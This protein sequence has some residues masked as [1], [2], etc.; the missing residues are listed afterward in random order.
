MNFIGL[1]YLFV[2]QL[3]L[4]RGFIAFFNIKLKP[5]AILCMSMMTGI[6]L[7][8][9][10][11]LLLEFAHIP[12]TATSVATSVAVF[13][14][15][16]NIPH[17]RKYNYKF[18][19]PEIKRP[20]I[21][22]VVF[23]IVLAGLM[24]PAVWRC[25]YHPPYARDVL[26]GAEA[27]AEYTIREKSIINSVFT[28]DLAST[29]NHLKPPYLL[30]LQII[31]KLLVH[32]FGQVW[33]SMMAISFLIWL[34]TLLK[35]KLHPVVVGLTMLFFIS[36][37]DPYAYTY[38]I[39]YDYSCMIF[40][41][42]GFYF[43]VKYAYDNQYNH[44]LFSAF[45]FG[46]STYIRSETL[47]L[48]GMT[49]P[50]MVYLFWRNKMKVSKMIFSIGFTLALSYFLYFIWMGIFVKHYM[51]VQFDVST[52]LNL[53][54]Q[55]FSVFFERISAMNNQLLFGGINM[56]VYAYYIYFFIT[57]LAAD[58]VFFR[59][60]FSLESAILLYGIAVVYFGLPLLGYLIPW[61]DITN[62]TKRGIYRFLPLMALYMR[63]SGLMTTISA[64]LW[65]FEN[66]TATPE[67]ALQTAHKAANTT[68]TSGNRKNKK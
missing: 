53:T 60:K 46:F 13:T 43:L 23:L 37:P 31:Y 57:V 48:I 29:N 36:I 19:M 56:I 5:L 62:T 49:V 25:F 7:V 64:A 41:F 55:H 68:T 27:M 11:P 18:V 39:L 59:K 42:A 1:I 40:F 28:I 8:S 47:V 45:L 14:L 32:P 3:L 51:P 50:L 21:Y 38:L 22:E 54:F 58:V 10:L 15:A 30:D 12:I 2:A 66:D 20:P 33:L 16:L 17:L 6:V 9:F 24:I 65:R 44:F 34:Y 35:E 63:S 52:Q 67:P 26:S 61:V 4:G